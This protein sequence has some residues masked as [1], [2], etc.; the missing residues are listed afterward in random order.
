MRSSRGLVVSCSVLSTLLFTASGCL[1]DHD[2][3]LGPP[4]P[5][6]RCPPRQGE[7]VNFGSGKVLGVS[8][9]GVVIVDDSRI[10]VA[11][12]T[13][14]TSR[15]LTTPVSTSKVEAVVLERALV[16]PVRSD[17]F[18]VLSWADQAPPAE[19]SLPSARALALLASGGDDVAYL[20]TE[21]QENPVTPGGP[22]AL[23]RYRLGQPAPEPL[24]VFPPGRDDARITVSG[25]QVVDGQA[26]WVERA[27]A[28]AARVVLFD[29]A[30]GQERELYATPD[31]AT[32]IVAAKR[33][34]GSVFVSLQGAQ[35][36]LLQLAVDGAAV[37]A[38]YAQPTSGV[39]FNDFGANGSRLYAISAPL[40][41]HQVS[42]WFPEIFELVPPTAAAAGTG[43]SF[44]IATGG[45]GSLYLRDGFALFTIS[46]S[47][48]GPG[49]CEPFANAGCML[50]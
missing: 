10:E 5:P 12:L 43:T 47:C 17:A 50:L 1:L 42:C 38:T 18:Q 15:H 16:F 19:I 20:I 21:E 4:E 36:A 11:N 37:Q 29:L 34:A 24:F 35:R 27:T 6:A 45:Y 30:T 9:S 49:V 28:G 26:L 3:L 23:E 31:G 44:A 40:D 22:R 25:L 7:I 14:G 2:D 41:A 13:D 32:R 46:S 39:P 33:V 48:C 8:G